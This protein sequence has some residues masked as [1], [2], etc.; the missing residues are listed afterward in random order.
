MINL[1][2]I[3]VKFWQNYFIG[4]DRSSPMIIVKIKNV[5]IAT[6]FFWC[7]KWDCTTRVGKIIHRIIFAFVSAG[8]RPARNLATSFSSPMIIVKIKNV[9][10]ATFFFWCPK[11]DC[12]TRVG[13]IIHRIIFAFVSAGPRPARNLATSFSSPMIIV[14]IKNV[15]FATFLFWCPKWDSNPHGFPHDFESCAS[16]SSAI[17]AFLFTSCVIFF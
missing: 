12:T 8:P 17:R 6:F 1:Y 2:I 9:A 16:A 14:K 15:A 11:W 10:I 3:H 7:P 13:K 5:A 4:K